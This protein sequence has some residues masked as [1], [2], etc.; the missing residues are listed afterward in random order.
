MMN[1]KSI[2]TNIHKILL[3][4]LFFQKIWFLIGKYE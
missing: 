1:Q 4:G 3:N 2:K